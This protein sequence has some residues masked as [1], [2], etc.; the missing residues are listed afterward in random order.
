MNPYRFLTKCV[1]PN[2]CIPNR[3]VSLRLLDTYAAKIAK[4]LR[5]LDVLACNSANKQKDDLLAEFCNTPS[6]ASAVRLP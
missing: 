3:F 6:S 4:N 5:P 1:T 2:I